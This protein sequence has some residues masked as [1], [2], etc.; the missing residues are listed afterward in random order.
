MQVK[1]RQLL[2]ILFIEDN[3][4]DY[5]LASEIISGSDTKLSWATSLAE[6]INH[7]KEENFDVVCLDLGM[8]ESSGVKTLELLMEEVDPLPPVIVLTGNDDEEIAQEAIVKGAQDYLVKG[9]VTRDL[10]L[11]TMRYSIERHKSEQEL[12]ERNKDLSALNV[13]LEAA[14]DKALESNVL[15]SQFIANVSHELRTPI[16]AMLG[17]IE[18]V[19][20]QSKDAESIDLLTHATEAGHQLLGIVNDL[21]NFSRMEAGYAKV[22]IT[23]FNPGATIELVVKYLEESARRKNIVL[24]AEVEPEIPNVQGDEKKVKQILLNLI[25]NAI[26]FTNQGGVKVRASLGDS[27]NGSTT[28]QFSVVDTGI[29]ISPEERR[30]LFEPFS[31]VDGS[32]TR[33]YGGTG[34]G[35]S[36]AKNY[37]ELLG[38]KIGLSS[39]K[40]SGSTFW[41]HIPFLLAPNQNKVNP[42]A[43]FETL[44]FCP[45]LKGDILIVEDNKVLQIMT[46]RQVE[47][48]GFAADVVGDG[49]Q[50][51]SAALHH[52]YRLILMDLQLP[53][54]DGYQATSKIRAMESGLGRRTPIIAVTASVSQ[55][56]KDRCLSVG[57]DEVLS[58]PVSFEVMAT[59]ITKW[60]PKNDSYL[61]ESNP[62]RVCI[63]RNNNRIEDI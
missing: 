8:P 46:K 7:L 27:V 15:K 4:D 12:R 2:S 28:V 25:G 33:R 50:A 54:I 51:I 57:M 18:I 41:F 32:N 42:I 5:I 30:Y 40:G 16:A 56:D 45:D 31:Q 43:E 19:S 23:E 47:N 13:A 38:G 22:E 24:V 37:T 49:R 60:V 63:S 20:D 55:N 53:V 14:R 36:I 44:D 29:G 34:L 17:L 61:G 3:E 11:R 62:K 58:K 26:K 52:H 48:A 59:T 6:G 1:T 39:I 35:L 10:L 21:L 9:R